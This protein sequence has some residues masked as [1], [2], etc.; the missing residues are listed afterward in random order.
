MIKK[1]GEN[2]KKLLIT[3]NLHS[4]RGIISGCLADMISYYNGKGFEVTVYTSQYSGHITDIIEKTGSAYDNIVCCGGDGS[5]N[6]AIN[7]L[8]RL[9]KRPLLGYIPCGSTNDFAASSGIPSDI[10][11]SFITAVDGKPFSIDIGSINDKFFSY[12]AGFGAFTSIAYETPQTIKN[13]LGYQAYI[14]T[15]LKELGNIKTYKIKAS[16]DGGVIEDEVILGLVSNSNSIAGIKMLF[17]NYAE[18]ND[19][20]F[21][22]LFIRKPHNINILKDIVTCLAEKSFDNSLFHSF[23]TSRIKIE[24]PD[25]IKWTTDGEYGGDLSEANIEVIN[26]A[27]DI[28]VKREPKYI[29][30]E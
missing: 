27:V 14:L 18:L 6:E 26:H 9:K 17:E 11:E 28:M 5:L 24:S 20:L 10:R 13:I 23:K 1:E 3:A 2:V 12:V 21:E 22:V 30:T 4:G 25:F 19:G 7:G 29:K 16:W 15:G 8:M